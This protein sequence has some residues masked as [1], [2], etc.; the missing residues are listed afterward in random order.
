M[1]ELRSVN[2]PGEALGKRLW[3]RRLN[4]ERAGLE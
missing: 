4:A 1:F 3:F 2:S